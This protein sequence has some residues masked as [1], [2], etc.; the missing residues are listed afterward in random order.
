MIV[1]GD[2]EGIFIYLHFSMGKFMPNDYSFA[3]HF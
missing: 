3:H 2:L 1:F